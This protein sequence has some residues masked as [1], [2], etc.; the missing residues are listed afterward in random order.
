MDYVTLVDL[1][2]VFYIVLTKYFKVQLTCSFILCTQ[3]HL[4]YYLKIKI[5]LYLDGARI[6]IILTTTIDKEP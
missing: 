1:E 2:I 3:K 4:V 5:A 6:L